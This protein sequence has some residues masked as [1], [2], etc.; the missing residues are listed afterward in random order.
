MLPLYK[1]LNSQTILFRG[2]L[3][4]A[5]KGLTIFDKIPEG[6]SLNIPPFL[7]KKSHFRKQEAEVCY[8]IAR[9]FIMVPYM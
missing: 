7:R 2:D 5:D 6:G 1:T 4:L 9:E 8:K 3:I